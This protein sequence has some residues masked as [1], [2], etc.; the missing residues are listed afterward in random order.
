MWTARAR[1]LLLATAV[2]AAGVQQVQAQAQTPP[3][4][5]SVDVGDLW[6]RIRHKPPPPPDTPEDARK[7][8][9]AF[10]PI[11][12]SKPS[13][14]ATVGVG[15]SLARYFGSPATTQISSMLG[16]V[17]V[18][19]KKQASFT[20]KFDVFTEANRMHAG[21]DNR[22]QWTSQD[23]HG[24][25]TSSSPNAVTGARFTHVRVY[26]TALVKVRD[27]FAA[28]GG[29]HFASHTSIRPVDP[30]SAWEAS[31]PNAYATAHGFDPESQQS[32][33]VSAGFEI[34][35]RDN[36]INASRGSLASASYRAFFKGLLGGDSTW[37]EFL[38]DVRHFVSVRG[39]RRRTLA[40]WLYTDS[41]VNGVAPYFDLPAIGMDTYGRTGRGYA[42]GRFRGDAMV[43]GEVEYRQSLRRDNLL[44]MVAFAN[45]STYSSRDTGEKLFDAFAPAAGAGLRVLFSKRSGA[46]LCVDFA[47]GRHSHG[48]YLALQEAF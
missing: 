18:S 39:D 34:N 28:G 11:L 25:G 48:L 5:E 45:T 9:R 21:G 32:A 15:A 8:G 6:R 12:S 24:L 7:G 3:A 41:V 22:F 19:A 20:A 38:V 1:G 13:T 42:E 43:Y 17:S 35:T 14:G 30:N 29:L 2:L 4:S 47:V 26:E 44:G 37:Q 40:F 36:P 27:L 31:P 16:S 23:T 33:G 46:N 10:F